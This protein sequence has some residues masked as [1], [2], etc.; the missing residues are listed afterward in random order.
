MSSSRRWQP[1]PGS[2]VGVL[3]GTIAWQPQSPGHLRV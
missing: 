1:L 3:S 2:T